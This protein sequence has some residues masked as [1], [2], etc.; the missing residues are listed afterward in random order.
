RGGSR[1]GGL[2]SALRSDP[3]LAVAS[4]APT[5]FQKLFSKKSGLGAPGRDARDP[6]CTFRAFGVAARAV[7]LLLSQDPVRGPE[8]LGSHRSALE[9]GARCSLPTPDSTVAPSPSRDRFVYVL[10][11]SHTR[12]CPS[13]PRTAAWTSGPHASLVVNRVGRRPD[14]TSAHVLR[15]E[16][17]SPPPCGQSPSGSSTLTGLV[18][19]GELHVLANLLKVEKAGGTNREEFDPSQIR[20]IVYQDCERRGRN[21]LFDSSVKRKNEDISVSGSRCSSDASM[22]GEMMFGSVAM[23]YKGSTLKIHQ[24]RS[25]PQLMLSKVFTARTGSSICGSLN[26]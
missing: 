3:S 22:L 26:T 6:D 25:P 10:F 12:L 20:L 16:K 7:A 23:S 1:N 18:L 11:D 19:W 17:F 4:M 2:A 15:A 9:V 21:V 5:L 24:I 8:G 13:G 14:R